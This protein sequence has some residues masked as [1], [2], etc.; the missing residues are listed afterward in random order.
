MTKLRE[1]LINIAF[2]LEPQV[3]ELLTDYKE[4]DIVRYA[5]EH[6]E[7]DIFFEKVI[8]EDKEKFA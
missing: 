7:N 4:Q 1:D 2:L 3:D 8:R 5:A 6:A